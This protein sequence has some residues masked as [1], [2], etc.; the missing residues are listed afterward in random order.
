MANIILMN[1][2]ELELDYARYS[3]DYEETPNVSDEF[4]DDIHSTDLVHYVITERVVLEDLSV[5]GDQGDQ[6]EQREGLEKEEGKQAEKL[7]DEEPVNEEPVNE[8]LVT[9]K[10]PVVDEYLAQGIFARVYRRGDVAIK[11]FHENKLEGFIR[12]V[13]IMNRLK[14]KGTFPQLMYITTFNCDKLE[15]EMPYAS[16]TLETELVTHRGRIPVKGSVDIDVDFNTRQSIMC[17]LLVG[18]YIYH[19]Y[20]LIH[21]D[22]KGDNILLFIEPVNNENDGPSELVPRIN[23]WSLGGVV[24]YTK[25]WATPQLYREQ[26]WVN[27]TYHD[28][29]NLGV[30][31]VEILT[32]AY[33]NFVPKIHQ[34]ET[35]SKSI[36]Y[37]WNI[38]ICRMIAPRDSRWS[39][40]QIL[41][42]LQEKSGIPQS[43][44]DYIKYWLDKL[45]EIDGIRTNDEEH[46]DACDEYSEDE[47]MSDVNEEDIEVDIIG[48]GECTVESP[49]ESPVESTVCSTVDESTLSDE[50]IDCKLLIVRLIHVEDIA[51]GSLYMKMWNRWVQHA[52]L[53]YTITYEHTIV[54]VYIWNCLYH[55]R[56]YKEPLGLGLTTTY[57]IARDR[58]K[59]PIEPGRQ[60]R[61]R[62][63]F[64]RIVEEL[65]HD[66]IFC[67]LVFDVNT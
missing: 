35:F 58:K 23:D 46:N 34:L 19:R 13:L 32:L 48:E 42:Y 37:D 14:S 4:Y 57:L 53:T 28:I 43:D 56:L 16:R 41:E 17:K 54:S 21:G 63:V 29:Y 11:R 6:G 15:F 31:A 33:F 60:E 36:S 39:A 27:D 24:G 61:V 38:I 1:T 45:D 59:H 10:Q 3:N 22:I 25:V 8:E 64:N 18:V 20:G 7:E 44:K 66:D 47:S 50:L 5:D 51:A 26:F 9:E 2:D 65:L 55:R 30:L 49:V 40:R 12:E 52:G 67:S 62:N